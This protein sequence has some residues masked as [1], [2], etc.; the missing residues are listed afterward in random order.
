MK[1]IIESLWNA[2]GLLRKDGPA[3]PEQ[4]EAAIAQ[5]R[6]SLPAP[7]LAHYLRYVANG[8]NGIGLV[9]AGVCCECHIRVPLSTVASLRKPTD[10]H[11]CE[12]CG[13][14]LMLDPAELAVPALP[15]SPAP[16]KGRRRSKAPASAPHL[17]LEGA[18]QP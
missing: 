14:Y 2:Q 16:A 10:I 7:V 6:G 18:L 17:S 5:L 4:R 13:C 9:R 8:R 15:P 12:N 1:S 11:L 3:L